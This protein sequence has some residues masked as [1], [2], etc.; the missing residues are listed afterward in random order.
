M[1]I[2]TLVSSSVNSSM[3]PPPLNSGNLYMYEF[4]RSGIKESKSSSGQITPHISIYCVYELVHMYCALYIDMYGIY[5]PHF[6]GFCIQTKKVSVSVSLQ[7]KSHI[8]ITFLG[9]A[10]PQSQSLTVTFM[11]LWAIY[12]FPGSV[13]IFSCSRIGRS[14]VRI[15]KSLTDTWTWKLELL[16]RNSFSGN[17]CFEFSLLILCSVCNDV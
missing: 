11:W 6:F 1:T 7:R 5:E 2:S 16:P 10:L 8:R 13:Y 15:C 9:I 17:T 12:I 4:C 14:I 3:P